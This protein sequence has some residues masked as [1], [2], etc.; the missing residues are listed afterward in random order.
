[1]IVMAL[2]CGVM[3]GITGAYVSLNGELSSYVRDYHYPDAVITTEISN[4]DDLA[5]V[6]GVAGVET[7]NA[8]MCADTVMK[9]DAGRYLSVRVFS[10]NDD[11]LQVFHFWST[12][13][14]GDRDSVYLEY[15]FA[16]HNGICAGDVVSFKVDDSFR[17]YVV[18][19]T[20]SCPETIAV[21]PTDDSWGEN[22]DFGFAYASVDLLKAE[23]AKESASAEE[24]LDEKSDELEQANKDAEKKL[25]DAKDQLNDAKNQLAEK[26]SLYNSS[27]SE[28]KAKKEELQ[29]TERN[30][31]RSRAE[32]VSNLATLTAARKKLVSAEAT[33]QEQKTAL[34]QAKDALDAIDSALEEPK[35]RQAALKSG[36]MA[37]SI[38]RVRAMPQNISLSELSRSASLISQY[39]IGLDY[40]ESASAY[41]A[42]MN[43]AIKRIRNDHD[44]LTST[45][46][47]MIV[48]QVATGAD[49]ATVSGYYELMEV[50][51]RYDSSATDETFLT[52]YTTAVGRVTEMN[53]A[54]VSNDLE[55][56]TASVAAM[57]GD[58]SMGEMI[59]MAGELNSLASQLS[60]ATGQS[61]STTGELVSA[62]D[63][64]VSTLDAEI[65]K[66]EAQR[67]SIVSTLNSQGITEAQLP[68]AIG[69]INTS[70]AEVTANLSEIDTNVPKIEDGINEIDDGLREIYSGIEQIDEQLSSAK[71]QLDDA[72]TEIDSNE[73]EINKKWS[74]SLTEFASLDDELAEA[75]AKLRDTQGYE[76]LFNQILLYFDDDADPRAT[77][78]A[79]EAAL[80][81]ITVKSSFT[82]EDSPVKDRIDVNVDPIHTLSYFMTA[83]F[84]A[85]TL[86]IVFLFMSLI[87]KQCRREIGILR[88]LGFSTASIKG[89]F[90]AVNACISVFAVILG[91]GV[92]YGV[93]RYAAGFFKG[94]FN[95]P[96]M[97]YFFDVKASIAAVLL[98]IAT[99]IVATLI[100]ATTVSKI[101]P[102]EAMSRPAPI[103][104]KTPRFL[105][106]LTKKASPMTKFSVTSLLR[107]RRRFVFSVICIAGSVMMI[108][109][110]LGFIAS[111]NYVLH[112]YYDQRIHYDCQII[113]SEEPTDETLA[114]LSGLSY[115]RSV[116]PLRYY[117]ATASCG[118]N[119]ID[120]VVN[121][122]QH[123]TELVSVIDE[124]D[125]ILA[126]PDDGVIME[127]TAARQL[128]VKAGDTVTINGVDLTVTD[129]SKQCVSHIQ[130]VSEATAARLGAPSLGCVILDIDKENEQSLLEVVTEDENYLYCFFTRL[131]LE[132][133]E[134]VFETFDLA[135]WIVI[136]FAI[137]I[138]FAIVM[139]TARTNLLEKKKELCILRTL[140]FNNGEISRS[141]FSQSLIQFLGA[142]AVGLPIGILVAKATLSIISSVDREYV[143]ANSTYEYLFTVGLVFAY[144]LISHLVS[145][146]SMKRWDM[147]ETVKEKE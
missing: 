27:E 99:G 54:I 47:Q 55:S 104:Y 8:R 98:T 26:E 95:L 79:A 9:S 137:I 71:Q 97:H 25:Q 118:A 121:A 144:V 16:E 80:G 69:K 35:S 82:Y 130:Y 28:A 17:D 102:S 21:R 23:T 40:S 110:S 31:Q 67:A 15:K 123:D 94:Y 132:G 11:D 68:G 52:S 93:L 116:Q 18:A 29:E 115:V 59:A 107:N 7:L 84:F 88:A 105:S 2:G 81:D 45:Q 141:W 119:E 10:Y 49:P 114:A 101:Q 51:R 6:A 83:I 56:A 61:I 76:D 85:V 37:A 125:N 43:A 106:A 33:L 1:M 48:A 4:R 108:F 41:A 64:A 50:V 65:A 57:S 87:I 34:M 117:E 140:G 73:K 133:N 12:A 53:A 32:L 66:A 58:A 128:G 90:C 62:Y 146:R 138:G 89:L 139:N 147:V 77:L 39:D 129:I 122:L 92:G 5:A 60:A 38:D 120:I 145:M 113:Y 112:Q 20:I 42:D 74:E 14:P 36:D 91:F 124:Q 142:C 19:G 136:W 46:A 109:S 3:T 30:L 75:Y 13:D 63:S 24:E 134:K 72:K 131:T 78:A 100:S 96:G 70:L 44:Y 127:Q 126:I 143:Y 22:A 103:T 111:K 86:V 135:S